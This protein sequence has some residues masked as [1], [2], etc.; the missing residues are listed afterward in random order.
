MEDP[1]K[2]TEFKNEA[3]SEVFNN[4]AVPEETFEERDAR[5]KRE[6]YERRDAEQWEERERILQRNGVLK[7][8]EKLSRDPE[9]A[10]RLRCC[11]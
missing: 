8:G 7:E 4:E 1:I 2:E 11:F 6:D 9:A 3:A 5:L 10:V